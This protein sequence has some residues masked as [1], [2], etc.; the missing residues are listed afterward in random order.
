MKYI[1]ITSDLTPNYDLQD[2]VYNTPAD[3]LYST[4]SDIVCN[5]LM[6]YTGVLKKIMGETCEVYWLITK[7]QTI[8]KT[9][10]PATQTHIDEWKKIVQTNLQDAVLTN[11]SLDDGGI[12]KL[13]FSS[14]TTN[15]WDYEMI[16][17]S[18]MVG[19]TALKSF[20]LFGFHPEHGNTIVTQGYCDGD[21]DTG[22]LIEN[23]L[24]IYGSK[25]I[26]KMIPCVTASMFNPDFFDK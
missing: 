18:R 6:E 13:A 15:I 24:S 19:P 25:N 9:S 7:N 10:L 16:E 8:E 23:D 1:Y 14:P 17:V 4:I 22:I 2:Q 12:I 5:I 26:I 21:F 20:Y 3:N 11:N